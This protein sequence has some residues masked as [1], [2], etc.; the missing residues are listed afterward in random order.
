LR[1]Y[2]PVSG[3]IR[4]SGDDIRGIAPEELYTKFGVCFQKDVLFADT[5]RENVSFGRDLSAED[6]G[7]SLR[8]AQARSF[9][10]ELPNGADYNL[11]SRGV[12]LSGGQR[13]RLLI[14]RALA[15]PLP[16]EKTP[17]ILILDDASSALDYR[18]DAE[19]RKS[20]K[21]NFEN[22]TTIIVA[23]RISSVMH[24]DHIMVLEQ[25]RI[26]GYG[27]HAELLQ[28]CELYQEISWSQMGRRPAGA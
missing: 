25:G 3:C 17:E 20:L 28:S 10:D 23:Q 13:Q 24:A 15:P 14:A 12:N 1:F 8:F 18:T 22:T 27:T 26:L 4:I 21:E 6:L 7:R 11:S 9:V 16:G 19:F 5:V 2:D